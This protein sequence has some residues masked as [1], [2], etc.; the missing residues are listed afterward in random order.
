MCELDFDDVKR[1]LEG[2]DTTGTSGIPSIELIRGTTTD[3]FTDWINPTN[4]IQ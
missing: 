2:G 3:G 1:N 4:S